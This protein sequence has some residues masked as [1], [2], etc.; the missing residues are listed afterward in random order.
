MNLLLSPIRVREHPHPPFR[1]CRLKVQL[2]PA[3]RRMPLIGLS[4][5]TL[6]TDLRG[7][8]KLELDQRSLD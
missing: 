5:Q 3:R 6:P 8:V 4:A 2:W 1:E 7:F